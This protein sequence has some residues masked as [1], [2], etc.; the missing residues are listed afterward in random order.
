M[1]QASLAQLTHTERRSSFWSSR[2]GKEPLAE[3]GRER[4]GGLGVT[5]RNG[6]G[7]KGAGASSDGPSPQVPASQPCLTLGKS[8]LRDGAPVSA[9]RVMVMR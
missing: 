1:G 9:P 5:P 6:G 3:G 2:E 8:G 7:L 4:A